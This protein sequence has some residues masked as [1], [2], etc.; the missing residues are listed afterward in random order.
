MPSRTTEAKG[1]SAEA[2]VSG[3][4]WAL[5]TLL[6][7]DLWAVPALRGL[8]R[9]LAPAARTLTLALFVV[10]ALTVLALTMLAPGF[11]HGNGLVYGG[12]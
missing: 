10:L 4:G 1:L 2:S 9:R 5:P 12:F 11:Q 3:M 6:P 8:A 7:G